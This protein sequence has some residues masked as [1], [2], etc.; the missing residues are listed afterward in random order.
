MAAPVSLWIQIALETLGDIQTVHRHPDLPEMVSH[1]E[2]RAQGPCSGPAEK[3]KRL[4]LLIPKRFHHLSR[5]AR[6]DRH[7]R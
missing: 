2:S 3:Q 5:E 6:V 7:V 4:R 1:C